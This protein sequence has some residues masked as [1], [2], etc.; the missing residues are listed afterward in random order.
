MNKEIKYTN[1]INAVELLTIMLIMLKLCNMITW[2]WF[3]VFLPMVC[4]TI[5]IIII[6]IVMIIIEKRSKRLY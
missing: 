5:I 2:S 4:Y 1:N 3:F 6:A